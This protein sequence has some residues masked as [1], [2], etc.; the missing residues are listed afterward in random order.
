MATTTKKPPVK[1]KTKTTKKEITS[2]K[3]STKKTAVKKVATTKATTTKAASKITISKNTKS[4]KDLGVT[5]HSLRSLNMVAAGLFILLALIAGYWMSSV[6]YVLTL[7]HLAKDDLASTTHTVFAPAIQSVFDV[8]ARWLVVVILLLSAVLPILYLTKLKAR[9]ASYVNRTRMQP[10]RWIDMAITG[11]LMTETAAILSGVSD[12]PTLKLISGV[13]IVAAV[14]GLISERQ[15]NAVSK[16]VRSAYVTGVVIALLPWLLIATYAVATVVYG[17][18]R[19]PWY[20]Y[21]LYVALLAGL[22]L[23]A[24]NQ[25]MS[26]RGANYL[27]VERNYIAISILTKAAF[28]IILIAGLAK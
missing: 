8:E 19:S 18:V 3:S 26:L 14:I 6:S 15:N 21:A 20:V 11:A 12:I 4:L 24:R 16:P 5:L 13:V 25:R 1:A 2:K 28:A 7:G 27:V 10:Y 9:Y 23:Q 22:A 17:M